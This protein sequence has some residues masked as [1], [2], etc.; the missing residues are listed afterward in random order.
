MPY[1][2]S[3]SQKLANEGWKVKIR[4]KERLEPPH[5]S[6]IRG[7]NTWRWGLR[8]Q[9]FL[10]SVPPPKLVPRELLKYIENNYDALVAQWNQMYPD[11][12][13]ESQY[14]EED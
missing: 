9:S 10:G 12:P 5:V 4:D 3:L 14:S 13:V 1:S 8:E 11:N 6:I 7:M 2:L